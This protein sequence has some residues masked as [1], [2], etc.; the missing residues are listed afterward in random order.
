MTTPNDPQQPDYG[1]YQYPTGSPEPLAGQTPS[2]GVTPSG[3]TGATGYAGVGS[4]WA[5]EEE[6]NRVAPWA[7]GLGIL[8][9]VM[10]LSLILTGLAFIAGGIG[11][12]VAIIAIVRGRRINGPGRRTAMSVTGL[13]LSA[14]GII[15]SIVFW[16]VVTAVVTQSGISECAGLTDPDSQRICVEDALS[17]WTNP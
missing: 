6:R 12:I 11:L 15:L 14:V 2:Y 4:S 9:L 5:M 1:A 8:A 16:A 13:V 3:S 10:G 7:L 17:E